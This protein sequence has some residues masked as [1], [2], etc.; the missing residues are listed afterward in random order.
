M[1]GRSHDVVETGPLRPRCRAE[2]K[3]FVGTALGRCT[4]A[5]S[6][7]AAEYARFRRHADPSAPFPWPQAVDQGFE[8]LSPARRSRVDTY[9]GRADML[10][11]RDRYGSDTPPEAKDVA[12]WIRENEF[13]ADGCGIIMVRYGHV[14][15]YNSCT[16]A[17]QALLCYENLFSGNEQLRKGSMKN[18]MRLMKHFEDTCVERGDFVTWQYYFPYQDLREAW[19][20]CLS[21]CSIMDVLLKYHEITGESIY[22]ELA[23]RAFAALLVDVADGGLASIDQRGNR[24]LQEYPLSRHFPDVLNGLISSVLMI[25]VNRPLLGD[26]VRDEHVA[27]WLATI[28]RAIEQYTHKRHVDYSRGRGRTPVD[29]YPQMIGQLEVLARHDPNDIYREYA[30]RWLSIYEEISRRRRLLTPL[31]R[32]RRCFRRWRYGI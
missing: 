22:R 3:R 20:S 21:Q 12:A 24:W 6:R 19:N 31:L 9:L 10:A 17:S 14:L 30:H 8:Q 4:S 25:L 15:H 28:R 26:V 5:P 23:L 27:A 18:L 13:A 7:R 1:S 32:V 29:Y 16:A 2:P 11:Y